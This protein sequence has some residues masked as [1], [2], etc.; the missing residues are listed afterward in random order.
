V[1]PSQHRHN[2]QLRCSLP[3]I[4]CAL[5]RHS[6]RWE[7]SSHVTAFAA[8]PCR[9]CL[10]LANRLRRG[11]VGSCLV[12]KWFRLQEF[13]DRA[14]QRGADPV[15]IVEPDTDRTLRP[16][17]GDLTQRRREP[18]LSKRLLQ[19]GSELP[20]VARTPWTFLPHMQISLDRK[21]MTRAEQ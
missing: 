2:G 5:I 10:A 19:L 12:G 7:R 17:R 18:H 1:V 14:A 9:R 16:H 15:Q 21:I 8:N 13:V 11:I 6:V 20:P 3:E 4:G